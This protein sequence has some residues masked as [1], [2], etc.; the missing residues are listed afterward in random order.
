MLWYQ[1]KQIKLPN[2]LFVKYG[3]GRFYPKHFIKLNSRTKEISYLEKIFC[4]EEYSS[5]GTAYSITVPE[6]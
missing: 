3:F 6:Q 4:N 2:K 5:Y 1:Y